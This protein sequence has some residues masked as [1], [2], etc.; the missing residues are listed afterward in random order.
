MR[1]IAP[2]K[3]ST[4]IAIK[5]PLIHLLSLEY[6]SAK[7]PQ[8]NLIINQIPKHPAAPPTSVQIAFLLLSLSLTLAFLS[9][10]IFINS[11]ISLLMISIFT[12]KSLKAFPLFRAIS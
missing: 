12:F 5:N 8:K 2:N 11:T 1:M 9:S 6:S 7:S 10:L 3:K 4:I